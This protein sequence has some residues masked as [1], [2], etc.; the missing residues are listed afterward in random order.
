VAA[1]LQVAQGPKRRPRLLLLP[2]Q[3]SDTQLYMDVTARI[4]SLSPTYSRD[5]WV[6]TALA[7]RLLAAPLGFAS[8]SGCR[9]RAPA[10][11]Q[12]QAPGPRPAHLVPRDAAGAAGHHLAACSGSRARPLQSSLKGCGK[13]AAPSGPHPGPQ[14][15]A[16]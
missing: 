8:C 7:W 10:L 6:A 13:C 4:S 9:R 15:S 16:R 11:A 14:P 5:Q 2:P 3:G 12:C 1:A